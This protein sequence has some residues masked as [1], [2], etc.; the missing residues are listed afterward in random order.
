[1]N[2]RLLQKKKTIIITVAK[3]DEIISEEHFKNFALF[4]WV[5][6]PL[7]SIQI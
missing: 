2:V 1:M 5:T 7:G 4:Q 6:V 3:K